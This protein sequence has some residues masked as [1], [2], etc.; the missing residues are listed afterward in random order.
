MKMKL[1]ILTAFLVSIFLMGSSGPALA[2]EPPPTMVMHAKGKVEYS[3]NGIK[4]KKVRRNKF[5]FAGYQLRTGSN[6]TATLVNQKS[7]TSRNMG[8]GSLAK[9]EKNGAVTVSGSLTDPT[10]AGG[11]LMAGLSQR[12][13]KAQR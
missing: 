1:T 5:L 8:A 3:K 13:A 10:P 11:N 9:I 12:F 7:G 6:S 4:W 2:K